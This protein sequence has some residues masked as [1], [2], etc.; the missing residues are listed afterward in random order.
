MRRFRFA[1]SNHPL[2]FLTGFKKWLTIP[3]V[4]ALGAHVVLDAA[5]QRVELVE[6]GRD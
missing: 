1:F 3:V 5:L 6:A 4:Q 2:P